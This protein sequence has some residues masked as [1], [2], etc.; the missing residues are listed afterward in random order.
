MKNNFF[1]LR[2]DRR[3]LKTDYASSRFKKTEELTSQPLDIL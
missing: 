1:D 3:S 2:N